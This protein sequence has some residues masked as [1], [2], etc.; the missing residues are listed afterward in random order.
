MTAPFE[1]RFGISVYKDVISAIGPEAA[2]IVSANHGVIPDVGLIIESPDA[3]ALERTCLR[4]LTRRRWKQ[5]T[6]IVPTRLAGGTA[7][8]IR[9]FDGDEFELPIAP[10][11]G[12]IDG[13]FVVALFPVSY[14]RLAATKRGE[15]PSLEKN[16]DFAKLRGMVPANAQSISYTDLRRTIAT[17]YDTFVPVLQAM[18]Q[19]GDVASIYEL[20]DAAMFTDHLYGRIGWR[21]ADKRG[22]HWYSHS[23]V[24]VGPF[25]AGVAAFA[26]AAL[27]YTRTS[28]E[29]DRN[30]PGQTLGY[31]KPGRGM[32]GGLLAQGKRCDRNMRQLKVELKL[33]KKRSG[34]Y[35]ESLAEA[36]GKM[37]DRRTLQVPGHPGKQ[38]RYFGPSGKNGIL[39]A[40]YPNGP[41]H[42]VCVI[43][44]DLVM[45][46]VIPRDLRERLDRSPA[47]K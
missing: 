8:V 26:G 40:G 11:F 22:M 34:D 44:I 15:R 10:T 18:P 43:T 6:G 30:R 14:Q 37:F 2:V 12:V 13:H 27:A 3:K 25:I 5:G 33:Y 20:P 42:N 46:R 4:L 45:K 21:V 7:H 38:Y 23:S 9:I 47:G 41:D 35:P 16:R 28:V 32:G 17:L 39:V 29:P 1:Q 24:D 19:Q 31:P 36:T